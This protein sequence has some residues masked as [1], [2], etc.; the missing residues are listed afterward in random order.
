MSFGLNGQTIVDIEVDK[1]YIKHGDLLF[2]KKGDVNEYSCEI[3]A[4]RQ[5]DYHNQLVLECDDI[6][7]PIHDSLMIKEEDILKFSSIDE[8]DK[9]VKELKFVSKNNL[10]DHT[11]KYYLQ[12]FSKNQF[13]QLSYPLSKGLDSSFY[14]RGVEYLQYF[15][16][17]VN[18]EY[19]ILGL[20]DSDTDYVSF[21]GFIIPTKTGLAATN[22]NFIIENKNKIDSVDFLRD[23]DAN[24]FYRVKKVNGS[25]YLYDKLFNEKI[26]DKA[27]K[28]IRFSQK[29]IICVADNE[30]IIYDNQLKKK[31]FKNL[32]AACDSNYVTQFIIGNKM[33]WMDFEGKYHD[34]FPIPNVFFCGVKSTTNRHIELTVDGFKELSTKH[35]PMM[36]TEEKDSTYIAKSDSII[37]IQYLNNKSEYNFDEYSDSYSVFS[38][39]FNTYLL[40]TKKST[41]LV[42]VIDKNEAQKNELLI[43]KEYYTE[44][45]IAKDSLS[46]IINEIKK[47]IEITTL[48]EGDIEA[49]GYYHPIRFKENN[50]YGYYP[51]NKKAKY[52]KL[53]KFN[54]FYAAF[55]LPNGKKGWL[56]IYGNEY[57]RD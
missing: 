52:V 17:W 25:F 20:T 45:Q 5:N 3:K 7:S 13:A 11:N 21:Q 56:D 6:N 35:C 1:I 15:Y 22:Y 30:T 26:I 46:I 38:F 12:W 9:W 10:Y 2:Y 36:L 51:Q 43:K 16:I 33:K 31:E 24:E 54:F 49:F 53:E 50:L 47:D 28:D 18:K 37:S 29:F 42:S 14:F 48:F 41:K 27:F 19:F 57:F 23:W 40:K 4:I 44:A 39:P 55:E 8:I 34:T 32:K